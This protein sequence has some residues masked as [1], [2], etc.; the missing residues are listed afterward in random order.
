MIADTETS[1]STID[2]TDTTFTESTATGEILLQSSELPSGYLLD[3]ETEETRR[4]V[5]NATAETFA[6]RNIIKLHER[7][8]ARS[9]TDVNGPELILFSTTIFESPEAATEYIESVIDSLA[10]N[11]TVN[12]VEYGNAITAQRIQFTNENGYR[13]VV[14]VARID[15]LV[16]YIAGSDPNQYYTNNTL[17]QF[18]TMYRDA[19]GLAAD[20]N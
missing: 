11:G 9:G 1:T 6:E 17:D 4:T 18:I 20:A 7:A 3:G 12:T 10:A 8:Y 13:T 14:T 19:E 5:E 2:R 16:M 15:N